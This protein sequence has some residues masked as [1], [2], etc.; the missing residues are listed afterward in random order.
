MENPGEEI[1]EEQDS[2]QLHAEAKRFNRGKTN[3]HGRE[4]RR[5]LL[6]PQCFNRVERGGFAGGVEAEEDADA[7]AEHE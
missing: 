4:Y 2:N 1:H 7:G 6:V 3:S 5:D